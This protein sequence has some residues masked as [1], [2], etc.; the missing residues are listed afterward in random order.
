MEARQILDAMEEL[1]Q[2][3][4]SYEDQGRHWTFEEGNPEKLAGGAFETTYVRPGLLKFQVSIEGDESNVPITHILQADGE[5][6]RVLELR[7]NTPKSIVAY[8]NLDV[9]YGT[10]AGVTRGVYDFSLELLGEVNRIKITTPLTLDRL[11]DEPID[12]S[13]C[14]QLRGTLD[15][16]GSRSYVC[17]IEKDSFALKRVE[18]RLSLSPEMVA[19][20]NA[21]FNMIREA[22]GLPPEYIDLKPLKFIVHYDRVT[23][24]N[25]IT[26]DAITTA[27]A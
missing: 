5:S 19:E 21:Q 22:E 17:W 26:I 9:A 3:C 10:I 8:P 15:K 23:F 14:Y 11:A 6:I 4:T 16:S 13:S 27:L 25:S 20:A 1:Y 24:N 12:D 2:R 18:L 7:E